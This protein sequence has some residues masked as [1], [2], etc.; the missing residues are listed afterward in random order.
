MGRLLSAEQVCSSGVPSPLEDQSE[1]VVRK[2]KGK[3]SGKNRLGG[4]H[5]T[6]T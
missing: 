6:P 2:E 5:P 1:F 3:K 4:A